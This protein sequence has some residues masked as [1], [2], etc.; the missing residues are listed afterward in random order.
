MPKVSIV[1]VSYTHLQCRWYVTDDESSGDDR[2]VSAG[3]YFAEFRGC[4]NG[5]C[6][7]SDRADHHKHIYTG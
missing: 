2:T 7:G 1:A 3:R 4:G 5:K 6:N